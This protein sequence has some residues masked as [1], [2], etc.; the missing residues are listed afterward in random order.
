MQTFFISEFNVRIK[1]SVAK[2]NLLCYTKAV[3]YKK[4]VLL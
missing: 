3:N 4:E 2:F 1:F